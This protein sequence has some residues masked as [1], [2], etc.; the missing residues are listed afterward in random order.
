MILL[1]WIARV[2]IFGT[3]ILVLYSLAPVVV[4]EWQGQNACPKIG[5]IPAC[6]LISVAYAAIGVSALVQPRRLTWLFLAGWLPVFL[7][8]A[9]GT[10]LELFGRDACPVTAAGTPMCYYSL[11]VALILLPAFLFARSN[12]RRSEPTGP[13]AGGRTAGPGE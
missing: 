12:V 9:S 6:Y 4:A 2:A 1:S 8:A 3:A 11:T 13:S 7:L 10:T 5:P